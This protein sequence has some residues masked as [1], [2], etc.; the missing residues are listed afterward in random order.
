M[1]KNLKGL[2]LEVSKRV[3]KLQ[4]IR[5]LK[6][7][8]VI[9]SYFGRNIRKTILKQG[10]IKVNGEFTF[11]A[12]TVFPSDIIEVV[13]NDESQPSTIEA[14]EG[15]IEI[16]YE[17]DYLLIVN[18]PPQLAVL[19]TT[20]QKNSLANKLKAYLQQNDPTAGMHFVSRLDTNTSGYLIIAKHGAI[21]SLLSKQNITKRYLAKVTKN[22]PNTIR[23]INLPISADN[24]S[25]IK[26]MIN[27]TSGKKA[28]TKILQ[29]NATNKIAELELKTGRTHQIRVHLAAIKAPLENDNLYNPATLNRN[30]YLNSAYLD[31][32]HP[33]TF[34][35]MIFKNEEEYSKISNCCI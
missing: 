3:I 21:H 13:L 30:Y 22:I 10:S 14:K 24:R 1:L 20:Y 6:L 31:F 5:P 15:L 17:D 26:Q 29:Y 19:P 2:L 28:I 8:T 33:I 7:K 16:T 27:F 11:F 18:K 25:I 12:T 4:V 32:F 35:R 23:Q 34:E 9:N